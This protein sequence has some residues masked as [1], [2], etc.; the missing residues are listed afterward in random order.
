MVP[1]VAQLAQQ[2]RAILSEEVW[3]YFSQGAGEGVSAAEAAAGWRSYRFR[4][5]VLRDVSDVDLG[6][7]LLGCPISSPVA[8]APTTLQRQAHPA[9][10]VGMAQGVAAASTLL[11]LSS[12]AGST[13]SDIA[14]TGAPWWLQAYVLADRDRTRRFLDLAVAAGARA[15]VLT[16]DTPVVGTKREGARSVWDVVPEEH[17]RANLEPGDSAKAADLTPDAIGWLHAATGLPVVVKGVL[18]ADDA[19]TAVDAGAAAVW[20]SN[21]GGRQLDRSVSTATAL[22][23]VASAVGSRV[24]VYVDGGVCDGSD[25]LTALALGAR[26]V[27]VG[28][29]ALWALTAGGAAGVASLLADYAV[30]LAEALRLAGVRFASD[31]PHDILARHGPADPLCWHS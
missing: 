31:V 27:F 20:V 21:H 18:R 17:L 2:A 3:R 29:P 16:A 13:F 1:A 23:E 10:E 15:V 14:A 30:E 11:C 8:I 24:E 7:S 9:G 19:V 12:N 28:R 5:H 25:V 22:P 4:P 6:T 26:A